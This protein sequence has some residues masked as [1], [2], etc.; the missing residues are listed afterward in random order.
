MLLYHKG[1]VSEMKQNTGE[2]VDMI[3][4]SPKRMSN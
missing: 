2:N 1:A 4:C 3:I